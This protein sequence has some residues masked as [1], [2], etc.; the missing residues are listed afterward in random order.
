MTL[1]Q[2]GKIMS[3]VD[4]FRGKNLEMSKCQG[5]RCIGDNPLTGFWFPTLVLI[6]PT[7][8]HRNG[9]GDIV[10]TTFFPLTLL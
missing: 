1:C 9:Y 7:F 8:T 5:T 4:N 3:I 10:M 6:P 2:G